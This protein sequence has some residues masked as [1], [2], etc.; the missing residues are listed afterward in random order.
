MPNNEREPQDRDTLL[1]NVATLILFASVATSAGVYIDILVRFTNDEPIS[2]QHSELAFYA[3]FAIVAA[4]GLY[5]ATL[6][7]DDN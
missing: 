6:P 5:Y 3:A 2:T 7:D 1:H 4:A